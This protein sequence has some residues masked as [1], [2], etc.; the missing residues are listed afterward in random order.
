VTPTLVVSLEQIAV[1]EDGKLR[2]YR[3]RICE[4]YWQQSADARG[5]LALYQVPQIPFES[6]RR[7]PFPNQSMIASWRSLFLSMGPA[8]GVTCREPGC[9]QNAVRL[10]IFCAIHHCVRNLRYLVPDDEMPEEYRQSG[11]GRERAE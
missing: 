5:R 11:N 4:S 3:C 6:W 1:T 8:I 10:S 2:L 9:H 7:T